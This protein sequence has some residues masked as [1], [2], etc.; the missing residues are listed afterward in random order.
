MSRLGWQ[1]SAH[2]ITQHC[3]LSS[4]NGWSLQHWFCKLSCPSKSTEGKLMVT[5]RYALYIA[6][7]VWGLLQWSNSHRGSSVPLINQLELDDLQYGQRSDRAGS[8]QAEPSN[9]A[10]QRPH[11][12]AR[13][14]SYDQHEAIDDRPSLDTRPY[15]PAPPSYRA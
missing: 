6:A 15:S 13:P 4:S 2:T 1:K 14:P 5:L 10:V 9:L 3:G 11:P 8:G 12:F 7:A